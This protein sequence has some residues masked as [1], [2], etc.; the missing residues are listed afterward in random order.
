MHVFFGRVETLA[1]VVGRVGRMPLD[2]K[3]AGCPW[4]SV[5][6]IHLGVV[7]AIKFEGNFIGK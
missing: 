7:Y 2:T 3:D 6:V 5:Y 1:A 4:G